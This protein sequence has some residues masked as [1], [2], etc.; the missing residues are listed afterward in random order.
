MGINTSNIHT[1]D[2]SDCIETLQQIAGLC[3]QVFSVELMVES[4][5]LSFHPVNTERSNGQGILSIHG[6]VIDDSVIH[7]QVE[8]VRGAEDQRVSSSSLFRHLSTLGERACLIPPREQTPGQFSL[9]VELKVKASPMSMSRSSAFVA[10]LRHMDELARFLQAEMPADRSDAKLAHLYKGFSDTLEPIMPWYCGPM[11]PGTQFADWAREI[12]DFLIGSSSVAIASPQPLMV[13][14]ALA[15]LSQT[16]QETGGTIG[17]LM[18]P[19]INARGLVTLTRKAPG[20]VVIPAIKISLGTSPYE[21]G[22]EM[23]ALLASLS[24]ANT[25]AIFSGS[26]EELQAVF[27]GGQGG[28]NDPLSPVLRHIPD[29]PLESL[30]RFAIQSTGQRYGGV[31]GSA[32]DE[33]TVTALDILS[34]LSPDKQR[35]VLPSVAN[36]MLHEWSKGRQMTPSAIKSFVSSICGLSES[37]AGLASRPRVMRS[38]HVQGL[39]TKVLTDQELLPFFQEQ[40]LA[41]EHALTHLVAR[42]RMECLTRPPHQPIRYCAQ[43][44]PA[45]GKSESASL[46]AR[47]LDIPYINID[48]ASMPD[49]HTAA[50]QLLGSGRG[51]VGSHQSGRLEQAAKHHTGV[52]IEV[53]DLDHAAP[54]VRST[55][56]DIFLQVLETGE[57]QSATGA[58]FSCANLIFAFTMNLP[59][60]MDEGVHKGIGFNNILSR[61]EVSKRVIAEIKN[62]LSSAFLSRVGTPIIFDPLDGEALAAIVERAI[63]NAIVRAVEHLHCR[64][65][66][67]V[68]D[69][70]VGLKVISSLETGLSTFGARALLE[71]GRSLAAAAV[72]NLHRNSELSGTVLFVSVSSDGT[73]IITPQ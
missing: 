13:D 19:M 46:L 55:L 24:K 47:R 44:P 65:R 23:R 36:K 25:P 33:L 71:H 52:V 6:R 28:S 14:L 67:V 21:L 63:K 73:I 60:G 32:K 1:N 58:M 69:K 10:E 41:Q 45:T 62:M 7:V 18:L 40:L 4:D 68:L 20:V 22:N 43:G 70:G 27:H 59:E 50:A 17:R 3:Q 2:T 61:R 51:I 29:M 38:S 57:A 34:G 16:I 72:T 56:A 66:D 15:V 5:E 8:L 48:A 9:W 37:L 42:L 12:A 53:S 30:V 31:P 26:H 39:F 64:I 35:R 54:S 49:Y 11:E